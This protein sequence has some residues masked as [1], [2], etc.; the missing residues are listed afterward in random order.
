[1]PGETSIGCPRACPELIKGFAKLTW[2][3]PE[4]EQYVGYDH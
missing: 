4:K 3:L 1:M 2:V